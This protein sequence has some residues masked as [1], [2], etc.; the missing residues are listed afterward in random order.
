MK[1]KFI[2]FSVMITFFITGCSSTYQM[3]KDQEP[4]IVEHDPAKDASLF[5]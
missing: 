3:Y 2:V 4:L 5:K 1:L